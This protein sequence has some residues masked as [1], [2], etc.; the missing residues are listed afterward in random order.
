M[1]QKYLV[2]KRYGKKKYNDHSSNFQVNEKVFFPP[3]II[4]ILAIE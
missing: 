1:E 4:R 3:Q 2:K